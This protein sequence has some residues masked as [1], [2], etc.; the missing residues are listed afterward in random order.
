MSLSLHKL[1]EQVM[2]LEDGHHVVELNVQ[3]ME[4]HDDHQLIESSNSM[5]E[6]AMDSRRRQ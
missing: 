1:Q 5:R 4:E 3:A 6:V 2:H